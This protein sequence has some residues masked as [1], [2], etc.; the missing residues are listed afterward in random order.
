MM[1]WQLRGIAVLTV[2]GATALIGCAPRPA[3]VRQIRQHG[4]TMDVRLNPD[5]PRRG[6]EG[7]YVCL[8]DARNRPLSGALVKARVSSAKTTQVDEGFDSGPGRY[9]VP[10]FVSA[11]A[12]HLTFTVTATLGTRRASL[13]FRARSVQ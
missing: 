9:V 2:V 8:R 10:L 11:A 13:T 4:L 7:V 1:W 12:R 5:P 6:P 3:Q